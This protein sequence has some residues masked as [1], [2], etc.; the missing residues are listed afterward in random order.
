[1]SPRDVH[2]TTFRTYNGHYKFLVMPF[3]LTNALA[4]LQSLMNEVFRAQ[5][6]RFVLVFFYD[7]LIYNRSF[8]EHLEHLQVL[9]ELL[10]SK[11]LVTK[12]SKSVFDNDRIEYLGHIISKARVTTMLKRYKL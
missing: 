8:K 7:I 9:L 12:E 2:K 4:T 3:G 5:L 6:R 1:M 10:R 11:K